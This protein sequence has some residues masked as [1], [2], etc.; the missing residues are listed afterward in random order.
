VL[1][2]VTSDHFVQFFFDNMPAFCVGVVDQAD[3]PHENGFQIDPYRARG[4]RAFA[5][6]LLEHG[7]RAGFDL[8]SAEELRL[9]HSILV[10]L[11]FLVPDA[12]L[13]IVP[14]YIKGLAQ[15]MPSARRCYRLGRMLRTFIARWPGDERVAIVAT[16]SFS[17]EVGGPKMG[18]VDEEWYAEVLSMIREGRAVDLVRRATP[19]RLIKSGNT[20]GEL[21]NWIALLGALDAAKPV[22]L[23][24]DRQPPDL[25]QDAHAYAAWEPTAP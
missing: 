19:K 17:L 10:P 9:D 25:R 15:P 14:V 13:P 1:V 4:H 20:G 12:A 6:G 3:G 8:A 23:E 21:L 7:L 2:I 16:G 24:A 22:F 5:A 11:H 18:Q